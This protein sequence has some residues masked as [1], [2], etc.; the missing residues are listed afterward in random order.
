MRHR[1]EPD[2]R[3]AGTSR[4]RRAGGRAPEAVLRPGTPELTRVHKDG[5]RAERA[6][7]SHRTIAGPGGFVANRADSDEIG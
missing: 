5:K 3:L 4:Q 6:G 7:D 2:E 1:R